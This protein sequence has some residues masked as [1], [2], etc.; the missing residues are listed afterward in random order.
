MIYK[1]NGA[2]KKCP[3]PLIQLR[4][5]LK[6][7]EPEDE[8]IITIT[9]TGSLDDI[10]KLLKKKGYHYTEHTKGAGIVQI[11]IKVC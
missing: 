8:C 11:N 5:L 2:G 1:Y 10:P 9:D 3:E 7:M 6:K 4:L